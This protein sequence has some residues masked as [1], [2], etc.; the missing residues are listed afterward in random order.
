MF[1]K[2]KKVINKVIR[3]LAGIFSKVLK[4]KK[5]KKKI[6]KS[7]FADDN[8]L[9]Y[10]CQNCYAFF[11]KENFGEKVDWTTAIKIELAY[12]KYSD[13]YQKYKPQLENPATETTS[14]CPYCSEGR[15]DIRK[16]SLIYKNETDIE[17]LQEKNIIEEDR[18]DIN[19]SDNNY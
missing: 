8:F 10:E 18:G 4:P 1:G 5:K 12:Q 16:F 2:I 7:K 11:A 14:Y 13:E 17:E 3:F 19:I 9:G 15:E 6:T